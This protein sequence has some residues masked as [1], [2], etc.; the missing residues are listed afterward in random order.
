VLNADAV[1]P[2]VFDATNLTERIGSENLF[3]SVA[4]R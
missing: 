3:P 1:V 2:D 4:R